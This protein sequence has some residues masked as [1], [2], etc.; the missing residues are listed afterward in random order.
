MKVI[1]CFLLLLI[2]NVIIMFFTFEIGSSRKLF[3]FIFFLPVCVDML[4]SGLVFKKTNKRNKALAFLCLATISVISCVFYCLYGFLDAVAIIMVCFY[5]G[6]FHF[7]PYLLIA[8][9][10][11]LSYRINEK[12]L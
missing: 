12:R 5:T 4:V 3:V 2:L 8:G 7:I 11:F 9:S 10:H 1:K 6:V